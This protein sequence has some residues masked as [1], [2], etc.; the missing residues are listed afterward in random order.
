MGLYRAVK[1]VYKSSFKDQRPFERELSG[2]RKYE[3][4]SR[5]HEQFIDILQI[6][7]NK[8]Q[9]YFYYV[10]E[11]GDDQTTG[12]VIDAANYSPKTLGKSIANGAKL[13][14]QECMELGLALSQALAEIHKH[15]LVHRDIK[16]SNIIFVN[17]VAKLAD[18]GLIADVSEARSYVGTEGYIPPEGPGSP[19]A[20]VFSLGKVLYEAST[21]KDRL[22]FPDLPTVFGESADHEKFLEL[23]EVILHACQADPRKRYPTAWEMYS[24]LL[25]IAAGKSVKR[26]KFLERRLAQFKR[27]VVVAL[28][29]L[30]I[31]A[32]VLYHFYRERTNAAEARQRQV[33]ASV[34]FGTRA[35]ESYDLT[36]SLPH[37]IDGMAL[38]EKD[39]RRNLTHRFRFATVL[40]QCPKLVQLWFTTGAVQ[41]VH[42]DPEG[43]QVLVVQSQKAQIFDITN[44]ATVSRVLEQGLDIYQAAYNRDGALVVTASGTNAN[45]WRLSDGANILRLP[46]PRRVCCARFSPDDSRIVTAAVDNVARIWDAK[47]GIVLHTLRKHRDRIL[48]ASF[49][50]DSG[51]VVTTSCDNTAQLWDA[52]AG[53]PIG[54]A[55]GHRTW[56]SSAAI[57]SDGRT[58]V[59]ACQ[60]HNAYVWDLANER[61]KLRVL[62]HNDIVNSIEFSADGHFLLTACLDHTA[63]LW[64]ADTFEPVYPNAVLRHRDRLN[65]ASFSPESRRVVTGSV[66]GTVAVWDLAGSGVLPAWRPSSYSADASR[67]VLATNGAVQVRDFVSGSFISTL[68]D[69]DP[70][71]HTTQLSRNGRFLLSISTNT[72]LTGP[73]RTVRVWDA[74]TALPASPAI[75]ISNSFTGA[76][77]SDGAKHLVTFGG[78]QAQVWRVQTGAAES[79]PLTH[80]SSI[81]S[82]FFNRKADRIVTCS[83]TAARVWDYATGKEL[84]APLKHPV[85]VR[86][87]EFSPDESRLITCGMDEYLTKCYA[88]IWDARTGRPVLPPLNHGD[89][90]LWASFNLDGTRVVTGS[91]DFSAIIWDANTGQPVCPP[92]LHQNQVDMAVFSPD[93]KWIVTGCGDGT[94]RV[95][96]AETGDPLTPPLRHFFSVTAAVFLPDGH[97]IMTRTWDTNSWLWDLSADAR[98]LGDLVALTELLSGSS[99]RPAGDFAPTGVGSVAGMW[100]RLRKQYP[101]QFQTTSQEIA[102]WEQFQAREFARLGRPPATQSLQ[103]RSSAHSPT[104]SKQR[105]RGTPRSSEQ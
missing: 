20:D 95:W 92:L 34:A 58:L 46:H 93:G 62:K 18:I 31:V 52:D 98:P 67:F 47:T 99:I 96:N 87:V 59:T 27:A 42:F 89:G 21:G 57:S 2:I 68:K 64:S 8:E 35:V 1:V 74:D 105:G 10:M 91:E 78:K 15:G 16:P 77:L 25:V 81:V 86:H 84:F 72:P 101:Q 32:A 104:A 37:F 19:A 7:I 33:G 88:Q 4:I 83:G 97:R 44:G 76:E 61:R 36:A 71:L 39:S 56:V 26:L 54:P 100:N 11:L 6:G 40:A 43:R 22:D 63:R 50:P 70:A 94:V 82:A 12:Q 55:F 85:P 3:P 79:A 29:A 75:S 23:N 45:V 90:V 65:A 17:G 53:Q 5:S 66:D 102:A 73:G 41:E 60:D 51:T 48:S 49:S 38:D 9:D 69:L 30:A 14:L 24:D 80:A 28:A 103:T 13:S